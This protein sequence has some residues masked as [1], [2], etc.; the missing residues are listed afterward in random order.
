MWQGKRQAKYFISLNFSQK[1]Q[2]LVHLSA[3]RKIQLKSHFIFVWFFRFHSWLGK[4]QWIMWIYSYMTKGL[5]VKRKTPEKVLLT[6]HDIRIWYICTAR[7]IKCDWIETICLIDS[8]WYEACSEVKENRMKNHRK[9]QQAQ[10]GRK[11]EQRSSS[12]CVLI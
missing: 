4:T 7:D 9:T 12:S 5:G 3:A 2:N 10:K 11:R 6:R 8:P 1:L